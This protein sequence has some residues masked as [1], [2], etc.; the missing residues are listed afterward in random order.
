MSGG[1]EA[2]S[3]YPPVLDVK[4]QFKLPQKSYFCKLLFTLVKK[5]GFKNYVFIY[6]VFPLSFWGR[7]H[8]ILNI[9]NSVSEANTG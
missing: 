4:I 1:N 7:G 3:Q 2:R 8:K 6:S 9:S 5:K